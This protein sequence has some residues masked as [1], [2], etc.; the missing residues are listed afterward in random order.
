MKPALRFAIAAALSAMVAA[1]AGGAQSQNTPANSIST[2]NQPAAE[3]GECDIR[4]QFRALNGLLR[5][6]GSGGNLDAGLA[7][8]ADEIAALA[9]EAGAGAAAQ[10]TPA[11]EVSCR[12][13]SLRA[14]GAL[15]RVPGREPAA[16]AGLERQAVDGALACAAVGAAADAGARMDCAEIGAWRAV[17]GAAQATHELRAM[18][19]PEG[20]ASEETWDSVDARVRAVRESIGGWGEVDGHASLKTRVACDFYG[21]MVGVRRWQ[22]AQNSPARRRAIAESYPQALHAAVDALAVPAPQ[23]PACADRESAA[24]VNERVNA[25]AA[26]CMRLSGG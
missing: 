13:I 26:V 9:Q 11:R 20:V 19:A 5:S 25:F 16:L 23:T 18:P 2:T 12:A 24:C 1:C 14:H 17:I 10:S 6:A 7:A 21:T 8:R 22:T 4:D 3:S 15:L